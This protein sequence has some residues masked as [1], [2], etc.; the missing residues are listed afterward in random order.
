MLLL[1]WL[2]CLPDNPVSL[3]ELVEGDSVLE[4]PLS[5]HPLARLLGVSELTGAGH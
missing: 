1:D 2:A 5:A 3:A 4:G